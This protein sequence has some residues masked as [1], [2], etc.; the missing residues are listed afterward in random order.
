VK[1]RQRKKEKEKDCFFPVLTYSLH[2]SFPYLINFN[3]SNGMR[4]F[5]NKI[6]LY[7]VYEFCPLLVTSYPQISH[8]S[9]SDL[10]F[11]KHQIHSIWHS[12]EDPSIA[13]K[14]LILADLKVN[15]LLLAT[16]KI[17]EIKTKLKRIQSLFLC[18]T[19][20]I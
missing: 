16:G 2:I 4:D 18:L 3:F 13:Q 6:Q 19:L 10:T 8:P 14:V 20:T 15:V 7:I 9:I 11:S 1:H 17:A 5:R 12:L